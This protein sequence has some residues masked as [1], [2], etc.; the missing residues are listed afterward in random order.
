HV[1]TERGEVA[2]ERAQVEDV[3]VDGGARHKGAESVT[4]RDQP[5]A[6]QQVESLAERHQGHPELAREAALR[7]EALPGATAVR[8]DALAE[9]LG[10]LVIARH[11][12]GQA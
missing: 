3:V 10:D 5:V 4:A 6:L 2:R 8:R 11:A 9:R 12:T 1:L 7:I